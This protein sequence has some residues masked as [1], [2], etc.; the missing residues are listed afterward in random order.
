MLSGY[1]INWNKAID[2][3]RKTH[4]GAI[5]HLSDCPIDNNK[6]LIGFESG[7]IVLWDL[8][9]R[10]A[11]SRFS[12]SDGLRSISWH[13]EGR[14][15]ICSHNDGS[16]TT[17]NVRGGQ[18]PVST[19]W[20]HSK[21]G[22]DLKHESCKPIYKCEWRTVRNGDSYIIFSGG[23]PATASTQ[24]SPSQ[25]SQSCVSP[26]QL[27]STKSL[28]K[29]IGTQ[30]LTV[31]HGKTTTVLEMED[32]IIDFIT[33]CETA[34]EMEFS[35]PYAIVVLLN[36]DL[37]VVDLLSPGYPCFQNPYSMDLHES[38]VTYCYYLANCPTDLVHAFFTVGHKIAKR[39]G[40]SEKEWPINGGE[41][42]NEMVSY[43]EMII[44]GHADGSIKFWDA[45]S[46]HLHQLYKLKTAKLFEKPKTSRTGEPSA[47]ASFESGVGLQE[48]DPFAIEQL[49]FVTE[50]RYLCIGGASSQVIGFRFNKHE[51]HT[52][53]P[54]SHPN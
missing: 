28:D 54:V 17:W 10:A 32:N 49:T 31:I 41:W 46:V 26:S 44:T 16:L 43:P 6:L 39:S 40:F 15:F 20:P 34:Y 51:A 3:S 29:P 22:N 45:S 8:R 14:Q 47:G 9:S 42:G 38:P 35:D 7:C 33:L 12:Y 24:A 50:C 48:D 37:V 27:Q 25:P 4:P 2:L 23:L 36:N 11:D 30:S 19:V 53:V 52:E 1:V 13:H 5:V 21:S 18:K